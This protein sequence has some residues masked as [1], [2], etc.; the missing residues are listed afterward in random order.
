MNFAAPAAVAIPIRCRCSA[1]LDADTATD[2]QL[3]RNPCDLAVGHHL[4]TQLACC[5]RKHRVCVSAMGMLLHLD[6]SSDRKACTGTVRKSSKWGGGGANAA[7]L[8]DFDDR[9][10]LLALLAALFGLTP[11]NQMAWWG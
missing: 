3:L 2:A 7:M 5:M 6:A 8:T 11:S 4:D 10:A 1:H 9:A